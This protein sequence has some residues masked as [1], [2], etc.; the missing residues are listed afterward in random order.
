MILIL[1]IHTAILCPSLNKSDNVDITYT[2]NVGTDHHNLG[3][4]ATYSCNKDYFL[5]MSA[6]NSSQIR[7]CVDDKNNDA[8]GVFNGTAPTC[9]RK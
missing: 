5:N 8:E 6:V 7:T 4:V 2:P 1:I 3:T 9:V